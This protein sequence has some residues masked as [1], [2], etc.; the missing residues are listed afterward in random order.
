M[1][2]ELSSINSVPTFKFYFD[3]KQ[4]DT[5]SGANLTRIR[6]NV[7]KLKKMV[8]K[9][10][11]GASKSEDEDEEK[12]NDQTNEKTVIHVTKKEDF[13]KHL[14]MGKTVVDFSASWYVKF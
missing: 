8:N 9:P 11:D 1:P 14:S 12:K 3:G 10:E 2:N 5:F 7:D 13:V 6:D 4:I